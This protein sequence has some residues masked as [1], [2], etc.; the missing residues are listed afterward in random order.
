MARFCP[1]FSGSSGNCTYIGTPDG[2]ILVD[3]GVSAK[4]IDGALKERDIDPSSIRAVFITHEHSDHISGLRVLTKRYGYKIY[5]SAGTLDAMLDSCA[6]TESVRIEVMP[7]RGVEEA[8]MWITGFHT[9]HD[10]RE[11]LGFRVRTA[12]ER[13]LA[14]ATDTGCIT[15]GIRRNLLGC[16]LI[17]LESNHDLQMLRN[18]PYP[19]YLKKRILADTGHLSNTCCASELPGLAR[20]G[21]TRFVLGHLSRENN[22]PEI[23]YRESLRSLLEAGFTEKKDFL[24]SVAP[25]TATA[26]VMLL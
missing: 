2:G 8:G 3:V 10:S 14:V 15:D 26:P 9:S 5:A 17:L 20:S 12:D 6:L 19:Y 4:R 11:S 21:V 22:E 25:R 13:N 7:E 16:D 1:L 23:A 24:L 18:G